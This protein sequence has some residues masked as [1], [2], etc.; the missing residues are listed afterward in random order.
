M[1]ARFIPKVTADIEVQPITRSILRMRTKITPQF[2]WND[3]YHGS[4]LQSFWLWVEDPESDCMHY[5]EM[6]SLSKKQVSKFVVIFGL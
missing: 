2:R 3:K 4:Q 6:I 1:V 5:S